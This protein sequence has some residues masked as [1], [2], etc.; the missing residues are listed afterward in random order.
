MSFGVSFTSFEPTRIFSEFGYT[1]IRATHTPR[2]ISKNGETFKTVQK[3]CIHLFEYI[4]FLCLLT[5]TNS[6]KYAFV[7]NRSL[8]RIKTHNVINDFRKRVRLLTS[9][10][11]LLDLTTESTIFIVY[12]GTLKWNNLICACLYL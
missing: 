4:Q 10:T 11:L 6:N 1:S 9:E 8:R 5:A 7:G 3:T 2:Y 12:D